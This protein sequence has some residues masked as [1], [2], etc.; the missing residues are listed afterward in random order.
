[1]CVVCECVGHR[2]IY[3]YSFEAIQMYKPVEL[4]KQSID[5]LD[6]TPN[7]QTN[8]R[9]TFMCEEDKEDVVVRNDDAKCVITMREKKPR[10]VTK[11]S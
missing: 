6:Y 10:K 1:M 2:K 7:I 3:L 9:K 8:Q 11:N 5:S 4:A